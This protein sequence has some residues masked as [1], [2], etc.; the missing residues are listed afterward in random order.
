MNWPQ[1]RILS[2]ALD[3]WLETLCEGD[4]SGCSCLRARPES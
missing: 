3:A 4:M 1:Q 2:D